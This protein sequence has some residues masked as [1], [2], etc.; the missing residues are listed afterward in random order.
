MEEYR[1]D[2]LVYHG[3]LK[4]KWGVA[5]LNAME[6]F[7]QHF[8][9]ISIPLLLVHGDADQLVHIG[10]SQFGYHTASSTDKT[11]EIFKGGF[12]ETLNDLERDRFLLLVGE[13]L[14]RQ[15]DAVARS[16]A[17]EG[18]AAEQEV[19]G[20]PI[21]GE[22]PEDAPKAGESPEDAPKVGESPEDAS[23]AGESPTDVPPEDAP[24]KDEETVETESTENVGQG[25]GPQ[26][27]PVEEEPPNEELLPEDPQPS[28]QLSQGAVE[29]GELENED[30]Q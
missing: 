8:S 17:G 14:D 9:E 19:K 21:A 24:T 18:T 30:E 3:K 10:S 15:L 20:A 4:A 25:E 22:S 23:K 29:D 12:H 1:S 11:F 5:M 6:F 27:P 28:E 26:V 16:A 13:W 2:P 7:G